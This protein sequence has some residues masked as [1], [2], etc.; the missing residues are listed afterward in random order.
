[1]K[2]QEKFVKILHSFLTSHMCVFN[3]LLN[4]SSAGFRRPNQGSV[5][6][7]L[8]HAADRWQHWMARCHLYTSLLLCFSNFL[9]VFDFGFFKT[10]SLVDQCSFEL[11]IFL[12]LPP[13]CQ[14]SRLVQ[15]H[16]FVWSMESNSWYLY[17]LAKCSP[18]WATST[19]LY[20]GFQRKIAKFFQRQ[21]FLWTPKLTSPGSTKSSLSIDWMMVLFCHYFPTTKYSV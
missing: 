17:K 7:D 4:M 13:K 8:T 1:M 21:H 19:A 6:E 16:C 11:L 2:H 15:P 12:H 5:W 14:N 20:P 18:K 3:M 9:I 10:G